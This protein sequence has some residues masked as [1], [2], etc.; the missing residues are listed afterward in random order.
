[1]PLFLKQKINFENYWIKNGFFIIVF[2]IVINHFTAPEN[3]PFNRN[4]QFPLIPIIASIIGG[5]VAIIIAY[6]NFK[7][8]KSK[9]F[10]EKINSKTLLLFLFSTLGYVTIFYIPFYYV[11][12][13]LVNGKVDYNFYY[14]LNGLLVSLLIDTV[15]ISLLFS[16]DIYKL[17]KLN[18]IQ[19]ILKVQQSGKITLVKHSEIAFMYSENKIVYIVKTDG[20]LIM[21]DFTL[22]EIENKVNEQSFFRTNR[23]T[24]IHP[25]SIE[26]IQ[27]IE[28][29]KLSV[30]LKPAISNE[31]SLQIN[32]SRY[33]KQAFMN[34]F[35][36]K[37]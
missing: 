9:Y 21:T 15:L 7:Y 33:K 23:Q 13:F 5:S 3:F 11:S 19:G 25:R 35:Q 22:N 12:N 37:T 30:L 16:S 34:W 29:G 36:N 31:E 1:M 32:I 17:H 6:F 26:Q 20:T 24:I 14:L 4:Y 18:S 8:F 10:S 28:N 27:S 2:S